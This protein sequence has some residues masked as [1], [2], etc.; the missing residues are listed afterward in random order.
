MIT[1]VAMP[2]TPAGEQRRAWGGLQ[3]WLAMDDSC[4]NTPRP[5]RRHN[6]T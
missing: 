2:I 4:S 6:E 3:S 1:V 5:L